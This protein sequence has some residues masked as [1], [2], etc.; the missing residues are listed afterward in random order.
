VSSSL[1]YLLLLG[2][3]LLQ[4]SGNT[5][6]KMTI[7]YGEAG[8]SNQQTIYI[9]EDRKRM[10]FRNSEGVKRPDG[11]VQLFYGPRLVAITRCDLG[12]GFELNL[13]TSEYTSAPYPP[14]PLTKEQIE[15]RGL[16]TPA[17]YRS[18]KP[19][20]RIEVSSTDTGERKEIFGHTAR[21]V[22]TIRKQIPL[23]G[24]QSEPQESMTDAWYIDLN[25]RLSCD[26]KWPAG[27]GTHAY[28]RAVN[29]NQ[30]I[31]KAEFVCTGEPE[32]G[33]ALV[34][35]MSSKITYKLPDGTK[36]QAETQHKVLVTALEERAIDPMLFKIPSGFKHVDQIQRSPTFPASS[37]EAENFWQRFKAGVTKLFSR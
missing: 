26:R 21:H 30:Q 9:S 4:A 14:K 11:S 34:S 28:L 27:Q 12:Q 36:K 5:A 15:G 7:R 18:E 6:I 20:L 13:D 1:T 33:F 24:S 22:I 31:E 17:T 23:D 37:S 25:Q 3:P 10:E 32:T 19:T 2:L 8:S 35:L 29:A 16:Q